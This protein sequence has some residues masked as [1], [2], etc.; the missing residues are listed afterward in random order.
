MKIENKSIT[1]CVVAIDNL[2]SIYT[3]TQMNTYQNH[4][5][6]NFLS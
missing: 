3:S 6:E 2:K 4:K 1:N 5:T